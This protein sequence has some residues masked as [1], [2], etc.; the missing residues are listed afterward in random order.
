M[1]KLLEKAA[2]KPD[3]L[4]F[5]QVSIGAVVFGL[6]SLIPPPPFFSRMFYQ[7]AGQWQT[8]II[9]FIFFALLLSRN[10]KGWETLQVV[11]VFGLFAIS[12]IYKWQFAFF[13]PNIIGGLLPWSDAF[14][15]YSE[16]ERLVSGLLFTDWGGRRPLFAS[17]LAV[18]LR[19]TGGDFM[20][21][22][23]ILTLV[24]IIA[25]LIAFQAVKRWYG[26]F[27]ASA[28]LI[29][30][31]EY[32][33][34]FAGKTLTE[35]LGFALGNL[36][37][38]FLLV[39]V[40][41][42]S[43][44][45]ALFGLGI[46]TL[47]LSARAGAFFILPV[48]ILWLAFYF[49]RQI[50]YWRA[51]GLAILVVLAAFL[52]NTFMARFTTSLQGTTFSNYA[53][54][55]YG[56]ASGNKGWTQVI[57]DYPGITEPEVMPL[58][59]QKIRENPGLL[60]YGMQESYKD[61]FKYGGGLSFFFMG[62]NDSIAKHK[63][64]NMFLWG[65]VLIGLI[66][67]YLIRKTGAGGLVVISFFGV[68]ASLSL[69]PPIDSDAMRAFAAT[70]PFTALWVA[71]GVSSLST[72]GRKLFAQ[73]ELISTEESG[74][75]Y[76]K[77]A[78]GFAVLIILLAVP[79]PLLLKAFP[80]KLSDS[81]TSLLQPACGPAQ[82]LLQG[83]VFKDSSIV[84]IRDDAALESFMP[85]I[86]ISDFRTA[87]KNLTDYPFVQEELLKLT[88][89]DRISIGMR[90]D[91]SRKQGSGLVMVSKFP[92]AGGEFSVCGQATDNEKIPS[93]YGLYYLDGAK[94]QNSSLRFSQ[95]HP[96]KTLVVRQFYGLGLGLV[97]VLLITDIFG[98]KRKSLVG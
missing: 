83:F 41:T 25:I 70:I 82:E 48:L 35:Q 49:R 4:T 85:F 29:I 65:F 7:P 16:S 1:I 33:K 60:L 62:S 93:H 58:A 38:F 71:A 76:Q 37:L 86:R 87:I 20:A 43:F 30:A 45:R 10:G 78:L 5:A 2:Q 68:F 44:W 63:I 51:A 66:H 92:V 64:L 36:A 50:A 55:L 6:L 77:L 14:N 72:W 79:A 89:R 88:V 84:L 24:N 81:S 40:Q 53:Y 97:F 91:E 94:D 59:I 57:Q 96:T 61:Y 98:F 34:R 27:G 39:G 22:L 31:Y 73:K 9:L 74:L 47:A 56:L 13:D 12:L 15:Y 3:I 17:F 54:T 32:Y 11:M 23:I 52:L 46:L 26:A 90:L 21:A 75:P 42:R 18:V 80:V 8:L 95:W 67:S 19:L 28:Y 69:L